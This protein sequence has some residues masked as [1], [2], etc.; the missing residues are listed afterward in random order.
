MEAATQLE[1]IAARWQGAFHNRRQ[2]AASLARGGPPAPELTR[3]PRTMVV[4]RLVAPQLGEVVLYFQEFRAGTPRL[5]HRQ[6]VV[7]LRVDPQRGQVRAEQLFFRGGPTDDR[8][9]LEASRVA[10]RAGGLRAPSGLRSVL[11][12]R[13]GPGS[14]PRPHGSRGLSLPPPAGRRGLRRVRDS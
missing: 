4:E 2:V 14:L 12:G 7:V 9:P 13:A 3:E 6:R 5:A 11:R 1:T 8:P 10:A